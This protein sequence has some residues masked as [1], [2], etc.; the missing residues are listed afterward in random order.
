MGGQTHG[1]VAQDE[2]M[3]H[4]KE[5]IQQAQRQLRY[6]EDFANMKFKI[7]LSYTPGG[8]SSL[9]TAVLA[10]RKREDGKI[11]CAHAFYGERWVEEE[12]VSLIEGRWPDS[13]VQGF[14][15]YRL[16]MAL[17]PQYLSN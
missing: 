17:P 4:L 6:C 13:E 5:K 12:G 1:G 10:L 11:D 8:T 3:A 9:G 15:M 14:L 7:K 16:L 2:L